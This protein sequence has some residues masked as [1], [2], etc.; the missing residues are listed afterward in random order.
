MYETHEVTSSNLVFKKKKT[1]LFRV[2][3]IEKFSDFSK[4]ENHCGNF[5]PESNSVFPRSAPRKRI[6]I[7]LGLGDSNTGR[8]QIILRETVNLKNLICIWKR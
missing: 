6:S 7:I 8:T 2:K 3:E 4:H 5:L 1:K